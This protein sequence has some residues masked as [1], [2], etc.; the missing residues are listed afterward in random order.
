[1]KCLAGQF[2]R[3]STLQKV[4]SSSDK[5][6]SEPLNPAL[7]P[8]PID[9]IIYTQEIL[10]EELRPSQNTPSAIPANFPPFPAKYTYSFTPSY[11]PRIT[12]PELIRKQAALETQMVEKSL[13][14]L[15]TAAGANETQETLEEAR[16]KREE[17]WWETWKEMGCDLGKQ[18]K[19]D[20]WEVDKVRRGMAG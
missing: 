14:K 3:N 4:A 15:V 6:T 13:A 7:Q 16:A 8:S 5:L 17:V 20:I 9:D 18:E 11:P 2:R 19:E 1:M 12:E 10:P